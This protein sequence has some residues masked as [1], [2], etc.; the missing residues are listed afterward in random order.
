[1]DDLVAMHQ[2]ALGDFDRLVA[3][4]SDEDLGLDTPCEG[5][6]VADLLA[7]SIGQHRGFA[8]AVRQGDAGRAAYAPT[9]FSPHD[10]D[11]SVRELLD[12]FA[13]ADL[14]G[15]ARQVE[16][17]PDAATPVAF[18]VGAQLLDSA[19]HAWDLARAVGRCYEPAPATTSRI[20]AISERIPDG[21]NRE[22]DGA[23]FRHALGEHESGLEARDDEWARTLRLLGRDPAWV[24]PRR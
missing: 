17:N 7:H 22:V 19:V 3:G 10:W 20:L 4:L 6:L 24:P 16:L 11:A 1:M 15:E 14:A 12:A 5:W 8:T 2:T 18:I 21:G 13:A 9:P 23:A